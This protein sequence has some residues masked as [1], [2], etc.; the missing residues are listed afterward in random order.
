M[1][2]KPSPSNMSLKVAQPELLANPLVDADHHQVQLTVRSMAEFQKHFEDANTKAIELCWKDLQ[3]TSIDGAKTLLHGASGSVQS[4]FLAIMGPSGS[5]KT[6]LMNTLACRITSAT[7]SGTARLDGMDY[8][9]SDLKKVAGMVPQDD[10]L[11]G[12]LTC[13][14]TLYYTAELRLPSSMSKS[15]KA[16]RVEKVLR[17][18]GIYHVRHTIVGDQL[19]RGISGG[20]RKRLCVAMELLTQPRLLFLDEPT[21]GL[22]SVTALL[23]CETLKKLAA[24][25]LCTVVCTIHQPQSRIF[26]LF[27]DLLLLKSGKIVYYGPAA[28][29]MRFFADAGFPLPAETNPADHM[30][31]VISPPPPN[32]N[33]VEG[34]MDADEIA[35]DRI[36]KI[37]DATPAVI[38]DMKEKS[39][40]QQNHALTKTL[41]R[42]PWRY[43]FCILFERSMKEFVRSKS[44]I[45]TQLLQNII[46]AALIGGVFWQIGDTQAS[47]VRRQPVLFFC[48][49]NQGMFGSLSMINSFPKERLLVLRERAAGT[50]NVSAYFLSKNISEGIL[51]VACPIAFSFIAYF[52]I[53]FQLTVAKFVVFTMFMVLVTLAATSLAMMVSALCRTTSLSV[54][55][56]PM[57]LE[58]ARLFGSFFLSPANLP[59]HFIWLDYTSYVK[60]GYIGISLN[61]LSGLALRC[62]P[63]QLVDGKCPTTSGQQT[64][65]SLALDKMTIE[66]CALALVLYIL[67]CRFIA[68]LGIRYLKK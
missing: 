31:D 62:L 20:E 57:V 68:Y 65:K 11:N 9:A 27:D 1:S 6:T 45:I 66:G 4:R 40:M 36:N 43:Q 13:E 44:V 61:E 55:V 56:L 39:I 35:I 41:T 21:S 17:Q 24:S 50:Y 7:T 46:L 30:L 49:V 18:L 47:V 34:S 64:I 8:S 32:Y 2:L 16:L 63:T 53:G 19:N 12:L 23:L 52:M 5:G 28:D 15:D 10:L 54:T 60:F 59:K 33:S 38:I 37:Q 67:I 58:M 26:Q 14:E 29:T 25:G 51:Q 42:P 3:V 22:D 48:V